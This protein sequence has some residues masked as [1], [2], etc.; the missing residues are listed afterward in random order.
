MSGESGISKR[1]LVA[2][3]V[4]I[5]LLAGFFALQ[6][7]LS[8]RSI[9]YKA[10]LAALGF[11]TN[12][13]ALIPPMPGEEE[14][15]YMHPLVQAW[16]PPKGGVQGASLGPERRYSRPHLPREFSAPPSMAELEAM[17]RERLVELDDWFAAWDE[18]LAEFRKAGRRPRA[19]LP[20]N[21]GSPESIPLPDF[22]AARSMAQAVATRARIHLLLGKTEGALEDLESLAVMMKALE[23]KPSVLV[24]A[25]VRCAIGGL[26]IEVVE[27]GFARKAWQPGD[28]KSLQAH[29]AATDFLEAFL[30]AVRDGEGAAMICIL[31]RLASGT[32]TERENA[33][34]AL[35]STASWEFR[36]L[37]FLPDRW[38]RQNQLIGAELLRQGLQVFDLQAR[39]YHPDKALAYTQNAQRETSRK[40]PGNILVAIFVP[41]LEKAAEV[42]ARTQARYDMGAVHCAVERY[43]IENG[44]HPETLDMLVPALIDRVPHDLVSG[45]PP[46]YRRTED[47]GFVLYCVGPNGTDDGASGDDWVWLK[48]APGTAV[49]GK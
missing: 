33:S 5:I 29:L 47:G 24:S 20:G 49:S 41:N 44:E 35:T 45:L 7:W 4:L 15:F 27:E 32:K 26:C 6:R 12:W 46:V 17:E 9:D 8:S 48:A 10:Q 18:S 42:V 38:I 23:A 31:D 13:A 39:H 40:R 1:W 37:T 22:V 14:N 43:R 34:A 19:M 3:A 25:M 11:T 21:Y 28:L 30:D 2:C 16:L 36:L